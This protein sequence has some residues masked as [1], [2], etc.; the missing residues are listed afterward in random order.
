MNFIEAR[1]PH[2]RTKVMQTGLDENEPASV[3]R[4]DYEQAG[5]SVP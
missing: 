1:Y 4:I 3:Y 5:L 2:I